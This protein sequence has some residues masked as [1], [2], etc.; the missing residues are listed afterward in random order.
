MYPPHHFGGYELSCRDVMDRLRDRGH[1]VTV[2]T[3]TMRVRGVQDPPDERA[4]G[5][6]RELAFYWDDHRLLN[7]RLWGRLRVERNNQVALRRAITETT[8]DVVSAWNMGAMSLGLMT[9]VVEAGIP[10]VLNVCDEWPIHGPHIDPWTRMFLHRRR[11]ASFARRLTGIPT[12][13]AD[14]GRQAAFLY[15]SQMIREKV[16]KSSSWRPRTAS[17]VY[18]GIDPRDFPLAPPAERPWRWRLLYVGRIDVRKGI[19][20]AIEALT[21]LPP[22]A[23]LEIVGRGDPQYLAHLHGQAHRLGLGD[24]VRFSESPRETLKDRYGAVDVLVFP[25]IWEE[26]FGLVPVE[27]MACRTPVVATCTGGSREFLEDEVNCLRVHPGDHD[28]IAA[29]VRRL[30]SDG[31]LRT[32]LVEQGLRT[33][34]EFTV[35]ALTDAL[36]GWHTAAVGGFRASLPR[37]PGQEIIRT[38]RPDRPSDDHRP[39]PES[40]AP[41]AARALVERTLPTFLIVGAARSGTTSLWRYLSAHP[42]VFVPEEK[43]IHFFSDNRLFPRGV[44]WYAD[45]FA[46]GNGKKA[47]GESSPTY[48]Y[49]EEAA[50]RMAS[51][52]PDARLVAILRN[53]VDRAYSHYLH[54]RYHLWEERTFREAVD[55]ERAAPNGMAWPYYL[56]IGRYHPQLTRLTEHFAREQLLVLL[57]EDLI[58]DPVGTFRTLCRHVGIDEAI[59]PSNVG[60]IANAYRERRAA[61]LWRVATRHALMQRTPSRTWERV[62]NL[63]NRPRIARM[64][65]SEGSPPPPLNGQ[66]RRELAAYFADD[67]SALSEWLGRDLSTWR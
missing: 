56:M 24:R 5:V 11:L 25:S 57:F 47:V 63:L 64:L 29:A 18:T 12:T 66:L 36:E 52:V 16:E 28:A 44:D 2:L 3:T 35:D 9:T 8:P 42:D 20:V 60:E 58:E 65:T 6:R 26:P 39:F 50:A 33:A 53:P 27:A 15:N 7:P 4:Q 38:D 49:T 62:A 23:T 31:S 61:P 30:A 22:E 14:L 10:L 32:R 67:T 40:G 21:R 34:G 37:R 46:A 1:E 59:V 17:V 41:T 48:L 51:C 19:H 55:G 45:L 54:A 13:L 43:E